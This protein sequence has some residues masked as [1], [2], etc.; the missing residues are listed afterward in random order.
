MYAGRVFISLLF[1]LASSS[2]FAQYLSVRLLDLTNATTEDQ[3]RIDNALLLI[4]EVVNLESFREEIAKRKFSQTKMKGP[5]V[6]ASILKASERY[7]P[8]SEGVLDLN[9]DMYEEDSTTVGYT[10]PSDPF[11]HLNRFIHRRY[12]AAET[13]GNIFH[14]WLHKIGHTHSRWNWRNRENS[15]PYALGA[16]LA[17]IAALKSG[18]LNASEILRSLTK[19]FES[20]T[21]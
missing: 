4:E 9:I 5:Q 6:L 3:A 1:L 11:M 17:E 7:A 12:S 10:S 21:H 19:N 8:A 13:A 14:E 20:C 2:S 16:R 18:E 15:V